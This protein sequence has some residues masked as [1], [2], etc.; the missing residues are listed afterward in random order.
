[1]AR[2]KSFVLIHGNKL[3]DTG[4]AIRFQVLRIRELVL[5]KPITEWFPISQIDKMFTSPERNKGEDYIIATSWIVGEKGL[6]K[7]PGK[8]GGAVEEFEGDE[9]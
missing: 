8:I 2:T 1:M 7:L 6:D 9:E 4:K 3:A 5:D